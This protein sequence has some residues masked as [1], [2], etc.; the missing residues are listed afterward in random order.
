LATL[1]GHL[2]GY[3]KAELRADVLAGLTVT[4][5]LIPQ[6]VAYAT[7]AGL[8][9]IMGLYAAFLPA[10]A[11][12]LIGTSR[13]MAVGPVAIVCLLISS[14][15]SAVATPG[16]AEY[17]QSAT[18]LA[19]MVAVAF[20]GLAVIRA[21]FLV[22]FLSHPTIVGFNAAAG[23]LTALSQVRA[24][25]GIPREA[26]PGLTSTNPWPVF[27][28]LA[29]AHAITLALAAV[30]LAALFAISRWAPRLPGV[31]I[32]S[33]TG[34]LLTW[35][36]SLHEAGL[37]TVG[38]IERGLP[39][40][41]V[42]S[43]T[44]E[45]VRE[46]IP[47]ALTI[48][49]V[50]YAASITVVKAL[51]AQGRDRIQPNRELWAFS[52]ANAASAASGGFPVAGALARASVMA[53]AGSQTQVAGL[54]AGLSVLGVLAFMGP[55]FEFLPE[56]V[57]AAIVMKA[58]YGLIDVRSALAILKTKRS[59]TATLVLTFAVTLFVSLESGLLVGILLALV[60]FV[61]RTTAP[62]S[63]ELGRIVGAD[64]YRNVGRFEV[65][66]C[67]QVGIL[68]IDAPLYYANARFLEDTINRMFA[69]RS[70]MR[71][72]ILD[73][74][75]VSDMDATAIQSVRRVLT[76]LRANGNDLHFVQLIGPVRDLLD[77][78][79]LGSL[80]GDAQSRTI[81]EAAPRVMAQ[82]SRDY[83]EGTCRS[84]GFPA[85]DRIPRHGEPSHEAEAAR[86]S[87]QI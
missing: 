44:L 80:I 87:P 60:A 23:I 43:G 50:G 64:V 78:S 30:S 66:T 26:V 53:E 61:Y 49:V 65:E 6:A 7:L 56:A 11:Y 40:F 31:L 4:F 3:S 83:C 21:G 1:F 51:A 73:C 74:A 86:F 68:R 58:A 62:H 15:L 71:V 75:S 42:P 9:P 19:A 14:G 67:P 84:R 77:R 2:R 33:A 27:V 41:A 47:A 17:E 8:P 18:I 35:A 63:A 57:L 52:A 70:D 13:H 5:V 48:V 16:T 69:E 10:V 24:F 28:H 36:L 72:L 29:D 37:G 38:T 59:D 34:V 39:S 20:L 46:L 12:A 45:Q 25:F 22:N 76:T 79:G 54:L 81:L 55:V 32:V 85:C 82:I